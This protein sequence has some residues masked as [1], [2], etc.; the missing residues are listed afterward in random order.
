MVVKSN[1]LGNLSSLTYA[2]A[3][4]VQLS[5]AN[6]TAAH[7]LELRYVRGMYRE[8]FLH[9]YA[10]GNTADG[11]RLVYTGV[12][13][14]ND[15]AL[16]NLNTLTVAFLDLRVYLNG[17]TDLELRQ[18]ALELLLGQYFDQIHLSVILSS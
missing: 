2:A 16:E 5:T 6:L 13:L 10:I 1:L 3:Q 7:N 4:I 11:N 8:R 15:D 12:L 18:I 17:I 9:A 14:G